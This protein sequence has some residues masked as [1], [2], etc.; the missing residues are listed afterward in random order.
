M[1]PLTLLLA[2]VIAPITPRPIQRP[3]STTVWVNLDSKIYHCPGSQHYGSTI[4]GEYMSEAAARGA[5]NRAAEREA[6]DG[7]ETPLPLPG[8]GRRLVWVN[9]A[10][11]KYV[12]YGHKQ[13]G[14]TKRGRYLTE[15]DAI[16]AGY[17][18]SARK[19]CD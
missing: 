8:G 3:L 17:T 11:G 12:C 16:A 4:A 13:Y 15:P 6:C 18:A 9:T 7:L 2:A 14:R 10:S 19:R 1:Y 5:G